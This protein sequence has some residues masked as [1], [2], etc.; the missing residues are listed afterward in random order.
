MVFPGRKG[1]IRMLSKRAQ[2]IKMIVLQKL[3]VIAIAAALVFL[4]YDLMEAFVE[5]FL[6][7]GEVRIL[8]PEGLE[9][10]NVDIY[11]EDVPKEIFKAFQKELQDDPKNHREWEFIQGE[12]G[13]SWTRIVSSQPGAEL[14][15]RG[16]QDPAYFFTVWSRLFDLMVD[17][18]TEVIDNAG[19]V[20][21]LRVYP[22]EDGRIKK[23]TQIVVRAVCFIIFCFI[24]NAAGIGKA[25][26]KPQ[27]RKRR[28]A[29]ANG[30][31]DG[32]KYIDKRDDLK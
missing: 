32:N 23:R 19:T 30:Q 11:C 14:R 2:D 26:R 3:I 1:G 25:P 17:G 28:K 5:A 31:N 20:D 18:K 4:L 21:I 10:G 15:I 22:F 24:L 12:A 8:I 7:K 13:I 29:T 9:N 27:T 16:K 6:P